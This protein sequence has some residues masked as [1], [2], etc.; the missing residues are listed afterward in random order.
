[1]CVYR[2]ASHERS[3][4]PT[5]SPGAAVYRC[6][7]GRLRKPDHGA[8]DAMGE[9]AERDLRPPAA[10]VEEFSGTSLFLHQ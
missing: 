3:P 6:G 7:W 1:P 10:G 8:T 9:A 2:T 5:K 4:P